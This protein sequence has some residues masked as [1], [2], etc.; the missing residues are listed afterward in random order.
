VIIELSESE[1]RVCSTL[2]IERWLTKTGSVDAP[3]YA[4]GK[5][6]GILEHDLLAG[7]R[8]NVSEWAAARVFNISW[9]LPWYP[10]HLH[11]F[12]HDIPDIGKDGEVRTVRTRDAIPFWDKDLKKVIIGTKILDD[13]YFKVVEVYGFIHAAA[14]ATDEFRDESINGWRVPIT[15][16]ELI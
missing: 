15:R 12:R 2:A 13:V 16:M 10:N 9:N 6:E 8:A 4:K 5:S 1:V 3:N 7:I 14:Y 11:K